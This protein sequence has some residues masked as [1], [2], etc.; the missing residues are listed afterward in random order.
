MDPMLPNWL[1]ETIAAAGLCTACNDAE[2]DAEGSPFLP[3]CPERPET[4]PTPH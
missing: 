1:A 2:F 4:P 3:A